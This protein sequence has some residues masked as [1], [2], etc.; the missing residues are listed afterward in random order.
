MTKIEI[1][2][3]PK[4]TQSGPKISGGFKSEVKDGLGACG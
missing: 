1:I 3:D 4:G 2:R